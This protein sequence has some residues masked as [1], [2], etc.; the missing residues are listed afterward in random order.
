MS[1]ETGTYISDLNASNPVNT[2]QKKQGDDHLRLIKSTIKATFP[3]INGAVNPTPAQLNLLASLSALSVLANA[4]N[5][6]AAP[7][8][9]AAGSD[10]QVLR[11]SGTGIAFGQINVAQSAAITGVLPITNGGTGGATAAAARTALGLGSLAILSTINGSLW[12]GSDLA[13]ADGGTGASDAA[14][15]R[16][17]LGLGNQATK[18]QTVSTSDPSGT[19]ADGDVWTKYIA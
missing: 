15:A 11:R 3:N 19:P 5:G 12:S 7:S 1:L 16:T 6:A 10:H 14:T 4:T 18:N 2:D 8:A 13:L 9:L 17:N